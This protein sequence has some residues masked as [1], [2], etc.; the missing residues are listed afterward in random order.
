VLAFAKTAKINLIVR[1]YI[2]DKGNSIIYNIYA[3]G[4]DAPYYGR[5]VY[6][7]SAEIPIAGLSITTVEYNYISEEHAAYFVSGLLKN[8]KAQLFVKMIKNA[9]VIDSGENVNGTFD[10]Y[11]Y[12]DNLS[13]HENIAIFKTIGKVN[14]ENN[15]I[16]TVSKVCY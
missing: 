15:K 12:D 9:P 11:R 14:I 8:Y 10:L 1:A 3:H 7:Y 13:D 5:I 2:E 16:K 4:I 6:K